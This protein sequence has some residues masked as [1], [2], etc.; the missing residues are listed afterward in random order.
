MLNLIRFVLKYFRS[1]DVF[2]ADRNLK[3]R[4]PKNYYLKV[5]KKISR[6]I[7]KDDPD[8][9]EQNDEKK[10]RFSNKCFL[11]TLHK[12]KK[13]VCS[14]WIFFGNKWKIS[15]ID[16]NINT[17]KN[18]LIFD[19]FTPVKE[20]NRGHY[21]MLLKAIRNKFKNRGILIYALKKNL[22]S[23]KAIL[24]AGFKFKENLNKFS[25]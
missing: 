2:I 21:T 25:K 8:Y 16:H 15:E 20:R 3:Y 9:F 22:F 23:K 12:K 10:K 4:L 24:K 17:Y 6:I 14:G 18:I 7:F 1:V 13:L 5:N 11:L 19:F